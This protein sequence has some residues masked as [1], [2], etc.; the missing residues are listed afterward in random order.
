M[1]VAAARRE[2]IDAIFDSWRL[3]ADRLRERVYRVDCHQMPEMWVDALI[4][5]AL[6]RGIERGRCTTWEWDDEPWITDELEAAR[7]TG[8]EQML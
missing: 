4:N 5:H 8:L 3:P 7:R 1:T 6:R 2:L